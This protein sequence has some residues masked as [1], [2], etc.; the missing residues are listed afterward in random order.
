MAFNTVSLRYTKALY[1]LGRENGINEAIYSDMNEMKVLLLEFPEFRNFISTPQIDDKT[2]SRLIEKI[3]EPYFQKLTIKFFTLLIRKGR[4][5]LVVYIV[6][7]FIKLYHQQ[8]GFVLATIKTATPMPEEMKQQIKEKVQKT[9]GKE[10]VE[11]TEQIDETLMG[12][13]ILYYDGKCYDASVKKDLNKIK[14]VLAV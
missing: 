13:F 2:K 11:L 14:S 12:G 10:K 9:T 7:Q 3:F 8:N 1:E 5:K 6:L 4:C